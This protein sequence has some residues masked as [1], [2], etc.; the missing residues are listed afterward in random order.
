MNPP[1]NSAPRS[2][3]TKTF[4]ELW[5]DAVETYEQQTNN[6]LFALPYAEQLLSCDTVED[7][8]DILN[9]HRVTFKVFRSEGENIR[10]VLGPVLSV[11][12]LLLDPVAEGTSAVVP[13][14]KAIF[15]AFGA[16][17]QV[18]K[19]VSEGYDS[20]VLMLSKLRSFLSR[21]NIYLE[22]AQPPGPVLREIF[23]RILIQLL[24]VLGLFTRY[25]K[26]YDGTWKRL[27]RFSGR[28]LKRTEDFAM[29]LLDQSGVNDALLELERLTNEEHL[30]VAAETLALIQTTALHVNIVQRELQTIGVVTEKLLG[31]EI[32]DNIRDWLN[33]PDVS[34]RHADLRKSKQEG[35]CTWFLDSTFDEW[36]SCKGGSY[37]VYGNPG[38]GKSVLC[39]SVI[40]MLQACGH[41]VVYYYFDFRNIGTQSL[42]SLLSSLIYQLA[43]LSPPCYDL[44]LACAGRYRK[45]QLHPDEEVL[46]TCLE[47]MLLSQ[48]ST[49]SIVVIT[50]A[51]DECPRLLRER[52]L[53]PF[54]DKLASSQFG[55][56]LRLLMTSR[57]EYDIQRKL[58]RIC[59]HVL[60]LHDADARASDISRHISAELEKYCGDWPVDVQEQVNEVLNAKANGM[61]LWVTLQLQIMRDC[62]PMDVQSMLND[63]PPDLDTTYARILQTLKPNTPAA[64]R[65]RR[66][67][68]CIA[69]ADFPLSPDAL[70]DILAI[71]FECIESAVIQKQYRPSN[72]EEVLFKHCSCL[73]HVVTDD[74]WSY[75]SSGRRSIQFVHFTVKE[76]L[77]SNRLPPAVECFR[78]KEQDAHLTLSI[79]CLVTLL[80]VRRGQC[81]MTKLELDTR[82]S[83]KELPFHDY[84]VEHWHQY[85]SSGPVAQAV[86]ALLSR[87]LD[88]NSPYFI[89]WHKAMQWDHQNVT[90]CPL[91]WA[92]ILGL[93]A[94]V[95]ALLEADMT[96]YYKR[97]NVPAP[98]ELETLRATVAACLESDDQFED[99]VEGPLER[100]CRL[101]YQDKH[102]CALKIFEEHATD[103][104]N[105]SGKDSMPL[106]ILQQKLSF[107]LDK[108]WFEYNNRLYGGSWE[109][110]SSTSSESGPPPLSAARPR[111]TRSC[112]I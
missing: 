54:L 84:A 9:K 4:A 77:L 82:L 63:L 64:T 33:P 71:D 102:G 17:L 112:T 108:Y 95:E 52:D 69:F 38:G 10:A 79:M 11:V 67:L 20:L 105:L 5:Q 39:S 58:N 65:T 106:S 104:N 7:V 2:V 75:W 32:E 16:F 30:A 85:I 73:I 14:G 92:A 41:L 88:P 70:G 53:F 48:K 6:S 97:Q 68:E 59:T 36:I 23:L 47:S 74:D 94:N 49:Q 46:Y 107:Y 22:P 13:G 98:S 21:L 12:R 87:F 80:S 24:S 45:V 37:W 66:L 51:L 29:S 60:D 78:L 111:M 40:D 101:A 81:S 110:E 90:G 15:V 89:L 25:L 42:C 109:L 19:R 99:N 26:D 34:L 55:N 100:L 27:K 93:R 50:D 35:T 72:P 18:T 3:L 83:D 91:Y 61:F 76:Y 1:T 86:E 31:M 103:V 57:P 62:A 96:V 44:L 8:L 28:L 43:T 56:G